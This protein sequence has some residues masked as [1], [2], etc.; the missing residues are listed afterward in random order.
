MSSDVSLKIS[1][2]PGTITVDAL[3]RA[4]EAFLKFAAADEDAPDGHDWVI[5]D[6]RLA[7]AK[8]VM[9]PPGEEAQAARRADEVTAAMAAVATSGPELG[10]FSSARLKAAAALAAVAIS[11]PQGSA[12][13]I[14]AD[15]LA[16]IVIT[17]EVGE[18]VRITVDALERAGTETYGSVTG[19][20]DRFTL[21]SGR[22]EA[23]L[24]D[25]STGAAVKLLFTSDDVDRIKAALNSR[26]V[27]WG[28]LERDRDGR[29]RTLHLEGFEAADAPRELVTVDQAIG[30]LGPEWIGDRTSDQWVRMQRDE[31]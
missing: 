7:S 31:S 4:L 25:G 30:L 24:I 15:A 12:V 23:G 20:L 3:Q 5:T 13:E 6:L 19:V 1:G 29:K 18:A 28:L 11:L 8:V 2:A 9:R 21:R 17:R 16:P 26:V 22:H 27:A 10:V 14:A